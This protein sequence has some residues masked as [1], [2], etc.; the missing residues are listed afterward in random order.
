VKKRQ[1]RYRSFTVRLLARAGYFTVFVEWFL[2]LALYVPRFFESE[3]GKAVFP[4]TKPQPVQPQ[5]VEVTVYEPSVVATAMF[6]VVALGVVALVVY[7]VFMRYVPAATKTAATVA[8]VATEKAVPVVARKPLERI[9]P[10]RRK[11]LTARVL[12]WVKMALTVAPL[13]LVYATRFRAGTMQSQLIV[14]GFACLSAAACLTFM[15]QTYLTH[16][17]HAPEPITTTPQD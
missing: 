2:L 6:T 15:A 9:P 12:F 16:H 8:Q 3:L 11:A 7:V 5:P 17:W 14:F 13:A 10:R 1:A 4:T